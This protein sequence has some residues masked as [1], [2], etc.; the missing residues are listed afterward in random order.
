M[1]RSRIVF[2][3]VSAVVVFP[4]LAATLLRAA[5]S[6]PS[7]D[8]DSFY[9]Y[10]SVFSE[11]LGLIRQAYVDKPDMDALMAGALDGTTDALDPFSVYVP[12]SEVVRFLKTRDVGSRYSG[13]TMLKERGV[14][15]V[16]AVEKGSPGSTAGVRAGDI[17]AK[18]DDRS[19]RLM[20]V[21]EIQERL[22]AKPGTKLGFE[23]IRLGVP[24]Q[25]SFDLKEFDPPPVTLE[26]I[27]GVSSL[28]IPSFEAKT[29]EAVSKALAG[30][31]PEALKGHLLIDLRGV[32]SGAPEVAYAVANLFASGDLGVL[33][34]RAE[35]LKLFTNP[36]QA[37]WQGKV[38][39][40]VDRGTLGAAEVFA[41]VLRQKIKAELVG[42]RTFGHAGKLG[43]TE[44]SSGGQLL[45]TEAFYT[46]PDKAPIREGLKPDLLVDERSRTFL[47]KDLPLRDLILDRGVRRLLGE[48]T[49]TEAKAA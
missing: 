26:T 32:C 2:F 11:T 48:E 29:V 15:Y 6:K 43:M 8:E 23:V 22:T 17:V 5:E 47:E 45:Y 4:L 25:L 27:K 12:S 9:K 39:I 37:A 40:L 31:S 13:L 30:A 1:N 16:V 20:P 42:E 49:K 3:F 34:R 24:V 19:T 10:L 44:L 38:V 28:Y 35:E 21:W 7:P 46:G 36:A 33:K 41:A 18:I 14:A